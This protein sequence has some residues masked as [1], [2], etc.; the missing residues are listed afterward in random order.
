MCTSM[1]FVD[2]KAV[3]HMGMELTN[4][5]YCEKS[6]QQKHTLQYVAHKVSR[7][8]NIRTTTTVYLLWVILIAT[9]TITIE[10]GNST[11]NKF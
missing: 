4:S 8:I 2:E 1:R 5:C 3:C 11:S 9:I 10:T 7:H 6:A